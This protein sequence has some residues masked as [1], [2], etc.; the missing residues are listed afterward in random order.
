MAA[1]FQSGVGHEESADQAPTMKSNAH[2][3]PYFCM[4]VSV[5]AV[6][7]I[8]AHIEFCAQLHNSFEPA[9]SRISHST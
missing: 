3:G 7:F 6:A 8:W 5:S 4:I 2:T 1:P 9:R